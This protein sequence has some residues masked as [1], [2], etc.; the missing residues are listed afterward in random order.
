MTPNF[1]QTGLTLDPVRW[2]AE[3]VL[4][5]EDVVVTVE[6]PFHPEYDMPFDRVR[7]LA[8]Q[9]AWQLLAGVRPPVSD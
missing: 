4:T 3:A 5:D 2:R 6:F 1:R 7:A 9:R 8:E